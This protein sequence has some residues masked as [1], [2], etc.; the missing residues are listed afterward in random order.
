[1]TRLRWILPA[2]ATTLI[3]CTNPMEPTA[4]SRGALMITDECDW[5]CGSNAASLGDGII[6]HELDA[7]G[8][9]ANSGG[10]RITGAR[11]AGRDVKVRV[12]RDQLTARATDGSGD[13]FTSTE[14]VGLVI[15]LSRDGEAYELKVLDQN[16]KG[17]TFWSG[18]ADGVP[19]YLFGVRRA[20]PIDA[21][22]A[23]LCHGTGL[24]EAPEWNGVTR[25]ALVFTGDR[26]NATTKSVWET[27]PDD[28]WFNLACAGTA[29]AKMHLIRHTQAG[30]Y[31]GNARI[32]P[33]KVYERQAMLRM[34]TADYCGNGHSF[35]VDGH[36]LYYLDATGRPRSSAAPSFSLAAG[37]FTSVD[38]VFDQNGATCIATP[39]LSP[40]VTVA[41]VEAV[42]GHPIAPCDP[43]STLASTWQGQGLV[44][45]VNP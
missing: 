23:E 21:P 22:Y 16:D 15:L 4:Q 20:G 12:V 35:T 36:P 45:S 32:Y 9:K 41:D 6:F 30:S 26:Y 44:V 5:G 40:S 27:P 25:Q 14:L 42:C 37:G 1:M 18:E 28:P 13:V 2:A 33:T 10:I 11:L 38:A 19:T 34:Y 8:Y 24:D 17:L 29:T 7:S 3:A 31:S 39:R 43:P